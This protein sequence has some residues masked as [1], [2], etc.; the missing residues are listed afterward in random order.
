MQ[1]LPDSRVKVFDEQVRAVSK[2]T[3]KPVVA[4]SYMATMPDG[5]TINGIT[6][7]DGKTLRIA[8]ATPDQIKVTW[9]APM[10]AEEFPDVPADEGC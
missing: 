4:Q 8:S 5:A 9:L 3:G 2:L 7:E 10:D 1:A 6:D